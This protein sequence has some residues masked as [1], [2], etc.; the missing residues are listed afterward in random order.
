M[1][2]GDSLLLTLQFPPG[3]NF[4]GFNTAVDGKY[5]LT[6]GYGL[7]DDPWD[8]E[9]LHWVFDAELQVLD[10]NMSTAAGRLHYFLF[11]FY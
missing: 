5:F 10:V 11:I 1:S 3:D 9:V 4:S 6:F 7:I 2:G 8:L